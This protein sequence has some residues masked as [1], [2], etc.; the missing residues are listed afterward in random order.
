MIIMQA[1]K[2]DSNLTVH[3]DI[4]LNWLPAEIVHGNLKI[5]ALRDCKYIPLEHMGRKA[6]V[7]KYKL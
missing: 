1:S 6:R 7:I 3:Q 4:C 2:S 5:A